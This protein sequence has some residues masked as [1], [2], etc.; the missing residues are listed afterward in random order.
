MMI[1]HILYY[2]LKLNIT[3]NFYFFIVSQNMKYFTSVS[4]QNNG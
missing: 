4:P 3:H 1:K 2:L